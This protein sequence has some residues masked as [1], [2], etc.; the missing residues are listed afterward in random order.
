MG[1]LIYYDLRKEVLDF[2]LILVDNGGKK[3]YKILVFIEEE[4]VKKWGCWKLKI[5]LIYIFLFLNNNGYKFLVVIVYKFER[6]WN[7]V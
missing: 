2:L 4:R 7:F 5:N 6:L 3:C 1:G